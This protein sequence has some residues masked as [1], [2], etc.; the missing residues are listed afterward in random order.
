M[1]R[2]CCSPAR[3]QLL[4]ARWEADRARWEAR[5][6][7]K[8]AAKEAKERKKAALV[9][10]RV[11][12]GPPAAVIRSDAEARAAIARILLDHPELSDFGYGVYGAETLSRE[13]Y[14][15]QLKANRAK[16]LEPISLA[17]FI[18][19]VSWLASFPKTKAINKRGSSYG[20]KHHCARY[21]GGPEGGYTT[22]GVFICA[23][24]AAGFKVERCWYGSPNAFLGI[25]SLAWSEP[26]RG[27]TAEV[28]TKTDPGESREAARA[29]TRQLEPAE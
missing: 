23:A 24:I 8:K 12:A 20:L 11:A 10:A 3:Q 7:A 14:A 26:E 6:A 1:T 16:L 5:E 27:R 13:E 21:L 17:R 22:N 2:N 25:S 4:L 29:E 9:A 15:K 19:A 18:R 28:E